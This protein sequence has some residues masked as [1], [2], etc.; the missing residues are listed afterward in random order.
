METTLS[1]K[2]MACSQMSTVSKDTAF[3]VLDES[4]LRV[5]SSNRRM[6]RVDD[7]T[8]KLVELK[9]LL[10][11]SFEVASVAAVSRL[12]FRLAVDMVTKL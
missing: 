11:D 6:L 5:E 3:L 2:V 1:P 10:N 7:V 12:I 8:E 4:R 9:E